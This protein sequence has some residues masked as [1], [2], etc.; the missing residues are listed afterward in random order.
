MSLKYFTYFIFVVNK[1]LKYLLIYL[2]LYYCDVIC[3]WSLT[4][5]AAPV[6]PCEKEIEAMIEYLKNADK[7]QAH[8]KSHLQTRLNLPKL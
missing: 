3:W 1:S 7:T 4:R 8:A 5:T 6:E 2:I